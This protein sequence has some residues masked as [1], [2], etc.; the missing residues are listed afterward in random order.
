MF[1]GLN[2]V[3]VFQLDD[4][5]QTIEEAVNEYCTR[6]NLNPISVSTT[7][8]DKSESWVVTLVVQ[9]LE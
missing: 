6:N 7:Y 8:L 4:D 9:R 3:E 1:K 5:A 2:R